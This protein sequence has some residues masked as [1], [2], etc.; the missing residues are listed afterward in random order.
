MS[1]TSDST[2]GSKNNDPLE[3]GRL[4]SALTTITK[5]GVFGLFSL[6]ICGFIIWNAHL[7]LFGVSPQSFLQLEFLSASICFLVVT[8]VIAI[9]PAAILAT[10][11]SNEKTTTNTESIFK[12]MAIIWFLIIEAISRTFFPTE[13]VVWIRAASVGFVICSFVVNIGSGILTKKFPTNRPLRF[14]SWPVTLWLFIMGFTL[15][16]FCSRPGVNF[17]FV[18]GIIV[19]CFATVFAARMLQ[20]YWQRAPIIIR[21]LCVILLAVC[22]LGIVETFGRRQF[23]FIPKTFGGGQPD[24]AWLKLSPNATNLAAVTGITISNGLFGPVAILMQSDKSLICLGTKSSDSPH[25]GRAFE[26][27]RGLVEALVY[28]PRVALGRIPIETQN[29]CE[30]AQKAGTMCEHKCCIKARANGLICTI[31]YPWAQLQQ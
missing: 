9:P 2:P 13:P 22:S 6:Y 21:T 28:L 30:S 7:S 8:G 1:E 12:A 27:N 11:F 25:L 18:D 23:R 19:F 24:L 3:S 31:C 29:C 16:G 14:L 5:F 17:L 26:I 4:L 15:L 10:A 20:N